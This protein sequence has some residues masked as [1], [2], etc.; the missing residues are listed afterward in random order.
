MSSTRLR[1][2]IVIGTALAALALVN[3]SI[4]KKERLL[5]SGRSV[6]LQLAP[7]DPRSL[8]Q[9]DYMALRFRVADEAR[10]AL[11]QSEP[12]AADGTII[13]ALDERSVGIFRRLDDG[14]PLERDEVR[15]RYRLRFDQLK[16]A[17]NAF[18]F[19]E[20]TA[21][22]YATAEYGEFKVDDAGEMLL[23]GLRGADMQPLGR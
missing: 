10:Q 8:M 13:V 11:W 6:L 3:V 12:P 14:Q 15:L 17:T 16:F 1:N 2:W 5:A 20:G 23:T 22:L 21:D 4:V 9:G 7:V 18:F 19:E